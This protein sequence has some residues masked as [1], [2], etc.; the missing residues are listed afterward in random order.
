MVHGFYHAVYKPSRDTGLC[1][2]PPR[3]PPPLEIVFAMAEKLRKNSAE[4]NQATKNLKSL[5]SEK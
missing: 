1:L 4:A 5:T 2:T 3:H